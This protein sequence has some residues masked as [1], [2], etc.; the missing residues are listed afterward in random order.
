MNMARNQVLIFT[1]H[2]DKFEYPFLDILFITFFK[3]ILRNDILS[4]PK[5]KKKWN[6][7]LA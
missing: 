6:Q 4:M 3:F 7:V 2:D 1:K 5:K